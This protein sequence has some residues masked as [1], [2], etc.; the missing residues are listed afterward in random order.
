MI[1]LQL[2]QEAPA[3][4]IPPGS[5]TECHL[6]LHMPFLVSMSPQAPLPAP[7][8]KKPFRIHG[9]SI[10]KSPIL[11]TSFLSISLTIYCNRN[12]DI[13]DEAFLPEVISSGTCF[14]FT[15]LRS[16]LKVGVYFLLEIDN[17]IS[18]SFYLII[19]YLSLIIPYLSPS[20]CPETNNI[21]YFFSFTVLQYITTV[22]HCI[23]I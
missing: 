6:T 18:L 8:Q 15:P 11:S 9:S 1:F 4:L 3:L 7:P 5:S 13:P 14:S 21:D 10:A 20:T 2:P 17:S 19:P 22:H 16:V 12:L 23:V